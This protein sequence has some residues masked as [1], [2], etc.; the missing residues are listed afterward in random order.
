MDVLFLAAG[1]L[2]ATQSA[3]LHPQVSS[4]TQPPNLLSVLP[5]WEFSQILLGSSLPAA[6]QRVAS[7]CYSGWRASLQE[8]IAKRMH[9]H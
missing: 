1:I 4:D 9:V 8:F 3:I 5:K 2:S 6:S 7:C